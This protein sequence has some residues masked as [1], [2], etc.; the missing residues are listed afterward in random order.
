MSDIDPA[1][2]QMVEDVKRGEAYRDQA[3]EW[4]AMMKEAG[5]DTTQLENDLRKNEIRLDRWKNMLVNR[6]YYK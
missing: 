3:R 2:K 5:E 1:I 4:V 6:G